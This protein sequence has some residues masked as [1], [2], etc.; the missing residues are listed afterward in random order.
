[1]IGEKLAKGSLGELNV[2]EDGGDAGLRP[3]PRDKKALGELMARFDR[4]TLR[5]ET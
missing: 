1:M 4:R 3:S 5:V 2:L